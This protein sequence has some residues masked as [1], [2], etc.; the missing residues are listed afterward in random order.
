MAGRDNWDTGIAMSSLPLVFDAP[1]RG[2]PPRH[3]ADLSPQQR[4][5]AVAALGEKPMRA[6]QLSRH[7]FGRLSVDAP[8]M[9][10]IPA[11]ARG[12]ALAREL[13]PPLLTEVRAVELRR[14][15]HPQDA[16]AGPRRHA[17]GKRG[18]ALP[19]PGHGLRVQPGGLRDG[20]PV[21]C[22]RPGRAAAEPV[23]G[24][25][26]RPGPRRRGD[27]AGRRLGPP[28]RLSNV[29]FMGMGEPLANYRRTVGRGAPDLRSG[30]R[31]VSASLSARSPSPRLGWCPPY[32]GWRTKV[33]P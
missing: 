13:L 33:L 21:L 15:R 6:T 11:A 10:D 3:L 28:G 5:E 24:G 22:H 12:T 32:A 26:R 18:H 27:G 4:T 16:V 9:T 7:Y 14:R 31:A 29:V 20:L 30:A 17:A 8:G 19:G 2:Q 23:H 25:D 1:R